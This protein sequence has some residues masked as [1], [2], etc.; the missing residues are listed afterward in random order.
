MTLGRIP[1]KPLLSVL[2]S[3]FFRKTERVDPCDHIDVLKTRIVMFELQ[4][5]GCVLPAPAQ[6]VNEGFQTSQTT[7]LGS[8]HF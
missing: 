7:Q 2:N 6:Q 1:L 3:L 5:E 4:T 8:K